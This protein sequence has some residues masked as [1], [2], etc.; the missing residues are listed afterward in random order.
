MTRPLQS[1]APAKQGDRMGTHSASC[2]SFGPRHYECA[3]NEI[4]R[5]AALQAAPADPVAGVGEAVAAIIRD[6][7][8][9]V[10]DGELAGSNKAA[11]R[12]K[13]LSGRPA[14]TVEEVDS[15]LASL[16]LGETDRHETAARIIE[17]F[18]GKA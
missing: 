9:E 2:W 6:E 18:Q 7:C 12:I 11:A 3:L 5:L 16:M 10:R 14:P 1:D 13:E 4:E 17:L 15:E 8:F